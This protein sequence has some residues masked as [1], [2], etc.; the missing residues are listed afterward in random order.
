MARTKKTGG[1]FFG[2]GREFSKAY[3]M[4]ADAVLIFEE[5]DFNG[6]VRAG[7][8]SLRRQGHRVDCSNPHCHEGG[9]DLGPEIELMLFRDLRRTKLICLQCEG[10][11]TKRARRPA[12]V[13]TGCMEGTLELHMKK[14]AA[15]RNKK[16]MTQ[17]TATT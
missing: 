16:L 9:Y 8:H 14:M 15:Q 4:L 3:P 17:E 7:V 11:E 12:N 13:C 5:F 2:A 10:W 1:V 6:L